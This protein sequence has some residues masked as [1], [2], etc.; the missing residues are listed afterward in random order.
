[1]WHAFILRTGRAF[2]LAYDDICS[3]IDGTLRRFCR[4][5]GYDDLQREVRS[6]S[7]LPRYPTA[8]NTL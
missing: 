3:F 8:S 4:P 2:G 5:G 1:M 6:L 7:S